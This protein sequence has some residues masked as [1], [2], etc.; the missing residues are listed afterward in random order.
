MSGTGTPTGSRTPLTRFASTRP[1][2]PSLRDVVSRPSTPTQ[3]HL[4]DELSSTWFLAM[5]L[6]VD[7]FDKEYFPS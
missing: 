1:G 5:E 6:R 3:P 2:T 4:Y 7:L